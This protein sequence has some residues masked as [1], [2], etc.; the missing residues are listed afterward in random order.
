MFLISNELEQL[1]FKLE[2]NIGIQKQAGKVRK[3]FLHC[4]LLCTHMRALFSRAY[5]VIHSLTALV[6]KG[7]L[8]YSQSS[9]H[10][11]QR[12][13]DL[14]DVATNFLVS[15]ITGKNYRITGQF[16]PNNIF[17]CHL[18]K[19]ESAL[20][21]NFKLTLPQVGHMKQ[22]RFAVR[23]SK[24]S[25]LPLIYCFAEQGTSEGTE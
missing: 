4:V 2:K 18:N 8:F 7:S 11:F 9:R 10:F 17:F 1:E 6:F 16:S 19:T 12:K 21:L 3:H 23:N 13:M 24:K 5:Y 15:N 14:W 25:S 20:Y 22:S